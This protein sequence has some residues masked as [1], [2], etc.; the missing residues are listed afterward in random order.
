MPNYATK[1]DL[2]SAACELD[3]DKLK[4][5]PIDLKKLSDAVDKKI[6]KKS[7]YNTDNKGLDTKIEY[8]QKKFPM[9]VD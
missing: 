5:V 2:K 4:P 3:V 6:L 1:F 8:V 9:L 7:E